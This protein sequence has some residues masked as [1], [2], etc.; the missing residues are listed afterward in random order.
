MKWISVSRKLMLI[1]LCIE[2]LI[3]ILF[4]EKFIII[5]NEI[6]LIYFEE[7]IKKLRITVKYFIAI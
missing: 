1:F 4:K 3:L 6:D 2:K 7:I 5:K